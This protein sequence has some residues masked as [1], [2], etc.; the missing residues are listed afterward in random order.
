[1]LITTIGKIILNEIFPADFPYI[2][3]PTKTNLLNGIP[4]EYFVFEKGADLKSYYVWNVL[5]TKR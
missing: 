5:R 1:M 3:E 4:E 2:N